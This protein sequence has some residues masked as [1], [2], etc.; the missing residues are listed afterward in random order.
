MGVLF[1]F[2][3][4]VDEKIVCLDDL[5]F[6]F[7]LE[8]VRRLRTDYSGYWSFIRVNE[9]FLCDENAVVYSSYFCELKET[10]FRYVFDHEPN[11]IHVG[12]EHDGWRVFLSFPDADDVSKL[13]F[14]NLV[15]VWLQQLLH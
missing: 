2:G 8:Y 7:L 3:S 13:V 10:F 5:L 9:N 6:F 4:D 14:C 12:C 1:V 11:F 15:N